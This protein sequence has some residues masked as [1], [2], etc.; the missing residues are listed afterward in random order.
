MRR[1]ALLLNSPYGGVHLQTITS[2]GL[3]CVSVGECVLCVRAAWRDDGRIWNGAS[4]HSTPHKHGTHTHTRLH[5][6][7][8]VLSPTLGIQKALEQMLRWA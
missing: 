1:G 3:H 6:D 8:S 7:I 4:Y 2:A 5:A